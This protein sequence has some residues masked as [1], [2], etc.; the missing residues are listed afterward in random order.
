[1]NCHDQQNISTQPSHT[2]NSTQ[3]SQTLVVIYQMQWCEKPSLK[4]WYNVAV[5]HEK[6]ATGNSPQNLLQKHKCVLFF[7]LSRKAKFYCHVVQK[8]IILSI[9]HRGA[10]RSPCSGK[11]WISANF[12][13]FRMMLHRTKTKSTKISAFKLLITSNFE[14]AIFHMEM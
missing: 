12:R 4:D 3:N 5:V 9:Y 6:V 2:K 7:W 14:Q 10:W 8:N 11:F 1:M 13:K